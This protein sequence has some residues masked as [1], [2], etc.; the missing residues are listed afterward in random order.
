MHEATYHARDLPVHETNRRA[1]VEPIARRHVTQPLIG[2]GCVGYIQLLR[3]KVIIIISDSDATLT[4]FITI[5]RD[6]HDHN[7]LDRPVLVFLS[8]HDANGLLS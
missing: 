2:Q 8:L 5:T 3:G 6:E 1:T 4:T 7:A